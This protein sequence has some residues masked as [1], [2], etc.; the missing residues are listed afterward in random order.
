MSLGRLHSAAEPQSSVHCGMPSGSEKHLYQADVGP[1][2]EILHSPGD[3]SSSKI[4]ET[5]AL[6]QSLPITESQNATLPVPLESTSIPTCGQATTDNWGTL[7]LLTE[8]HT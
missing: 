7:S 2:P 3:R 5:V 4:Q 1:K 8:Q 6:D